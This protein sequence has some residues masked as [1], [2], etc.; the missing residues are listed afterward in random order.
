MSGAHPG[1]HEPLSILYKYPCILAEKS[2][3]PLKSLEKHQEEEEIETS[4]GCWK[5]LSQSLLTLHWFLPVLVLVAR[6]LK[7]YVVKLEI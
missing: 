4:P 6:R 7:Y 3:L 1:A 2:Y 5:P